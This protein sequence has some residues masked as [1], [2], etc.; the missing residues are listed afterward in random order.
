MPVSR[1]VYRVKN[2]TDSRGITREERVPSRQDKVAIDR[3]LRELMNL[4]IHRGPLLV[5]H[6]GIRKVRRHRMISS[7]ARKKARGSAKKEE[8]REDRVGALPLRPL[9]R[10]EE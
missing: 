5:L 6:L 7:V 3:S 1:S 2:E 8:T 4:I 10:T 9:W